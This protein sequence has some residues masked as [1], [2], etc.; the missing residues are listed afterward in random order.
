MTARQRSKPQYRPL[1]GRRL[2][3]SLPRLHEPELF[4]TEAWQRSAIAW[5]DAATDTGVLILYVPASWG[6]PNGEHVAL[7][8]SYR[9]KD[10]HTLLRPIGDEDP[11]HLRGRGLNHLIDQLE[12]RIR[13]LAYAQRDR[14]A[15]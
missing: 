13:H 9:D 12:G 11:M 8:A 7:H 4:E 2:V 6:L 1:D 14:S 3:A 15:A 10:Y 5:L